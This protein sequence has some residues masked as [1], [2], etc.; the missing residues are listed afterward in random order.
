MKEQALD[1]GNRIGLE[2]L[3]ALSGPLIIGSLLAAWFLPR[4]RSREHDVGVRVFEVFAV[5]TSL[6]VALVVTY[7]CMAAL[8]S[9]EAID[10]SVF[11]A[12]AILVAVPIVL[13]VL[14]GTVARFS[15]LPGGIWAHLPTLAMTL[16]TAFAVGVSIFFLPLRSEH[17]FPLSILI[18][19]VGGLLAWLSLRV[20]R[21]S[22]RGARKAMQQQVISLSSGGYR[23]REVTLLPGLPEPYTGAAPLGLVCWSKKG[24]LYLDDAG[25]RHLQDESRQ[26]WDEYKERKAKAPLGQL[27]LMEIDLTYRFRSWLPTVQITV[28]IYEEGKKVAPSRTLEAD[29]MGL[30]DVTDLEIVRPD[31]RTG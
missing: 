26:R 25:V 31:R 15:S 12:A 18:L 2:S 3:I 16:F 28:S 14:L 29:A 24:R 19:A 9:G 23:A 4:R 7:L 27:R 20:E 13:L 22:V 6:V 8:R 11:D 1:V 5:F 30:F 17:V 21:W 10:D